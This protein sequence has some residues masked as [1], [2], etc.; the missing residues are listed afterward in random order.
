MKFTDFLLA[1]SAGA[2]LMFSVERHVFPTG[3]PNAT[4][5]EMREKAE[6]ETP[7]GIT[8]PWSG[9]QEIL[10]SAP[11]GRL[12]EFGLRADGVVVW[13]ERKK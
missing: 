6:R 5:R 9:P 1:A 12:L 10:Y 4:A 11:D 7:A 8:R 13:R 2:L 3:W